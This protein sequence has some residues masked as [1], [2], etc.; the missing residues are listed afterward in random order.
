MKILGITSYYHETSAALL[1]DGQLVAFAEQERFS[2]IKHACG[3]FPSDA[4]EFCHK[5]ARIDF[6]EIDAL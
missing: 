6:S 1:L 5:K 4:I 3:I 2:R